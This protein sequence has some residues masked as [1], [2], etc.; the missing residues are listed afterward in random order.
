MNSM[1]VWL[2]MTN[3]SEPLRQSSLLMLLA[4]GIGDSETLVQSLHAHEAENKGV[5]AGKVG[6]LRLLLEQGHVL[7]SALTVIGG[8]LPDQAVAAIRVA[9]ATGTLPAALMDEARRT[10]VEG[11]A[12]RAAIDLE[13][14][15]VWLSAV[16]V[17][18][19][20]MTSFVTMFIVPKLKMIF[21]GFGIAL[22]AET[23][24]FITIGEWALELWMIAGLPILA[25]AAWLIWL[26][27]ASLHQRLTRGYH[28]FMEHWSRYWVPG[29]LRQMSLAAAT[30]LPLSL[31]LE[32]ALQNLPDGRAAR[33]F[34]DLRFRV[35]CGSDVVDAMRYTRLIRRDEHAFL[36]AANRTRHLDWGLRHLADAIDRRRNRWMHRAAELI[37]PCV[38]CVV[39]LLILFIVV[40]LFLPLIEI[41]EQMAA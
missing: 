1:Q 24:A 5:W 23:Q 21:T 18:M 28:R 8:L 33:R 36:I 35:Q 9:E 17:V 27:Y 32:S 25:A 20:A 22:P 34:R 38:I 40:S 3:K 16:L 14:L 19:V 11:R 10:M 15:I 29:L 30:D 31:A 4:A 7:S 37:G 13:S 12:A 41:I 26:F 39:G 2:F 6:Q